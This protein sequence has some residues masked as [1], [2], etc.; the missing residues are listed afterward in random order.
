MTHMPHPAPASQ[1][2]LKP[3]SG[4]QRSFATPRAIMALVLREM[5]TRYGRSPG[6]YIWA[7]A[8]PL[9]M[10]FMLSIAFEALVRVPPLGNNFILFFATGYL[11]FQLYISVS[12]NVGRAIN[13]SRA[14]LRANSST[15]C[16]VRAAPDDMAVF[17]G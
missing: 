9:G 16:R 8:E 17:D 15:Q 5:A 2:P 12:N 10:I 6:G 1:A 3:A 13:F 14:L 7:L 11:P 4:V